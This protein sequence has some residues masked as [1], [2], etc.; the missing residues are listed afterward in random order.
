MSGLRVF[1]NRMLTIIF[2]PKREEVS[3][4]WRD[5]YNEEFHYLSSSPNIFTRRMIKSRRVRWLDTRTSGGN[6]RIKFLDR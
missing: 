4:G 2:G 6:E 1:E 5:F 3:G